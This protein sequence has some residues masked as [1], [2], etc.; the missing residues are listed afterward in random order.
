MQVPHRVIQLKFIVLLLF[1]YYQYC[2]YIS[3]KPRFVN[4]LSFMEVLDIFEKYK[5][6]AYYVE[7]ISNTVD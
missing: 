3:L 5:N 2:K 7:V 6:Q 4:L 1:Q